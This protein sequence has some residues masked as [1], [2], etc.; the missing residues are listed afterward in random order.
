M[1][2]H[3]AN[4]L[5]LQKIGQEINPESL[6]KLDLPECYRKN[7]SVIGCIQYIDR[8]GNL[9]TNIHRS[10]VKGHNWSLEIK[11]RKIETRETY[12][13][14]KLGEL[15]AL[16]VSHGWVEVAVNSGNAQLALGVENGYQVRIF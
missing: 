9:V 10:Y 12:S 5:S 1:G 16:I 15:I 13:D 4:G 6:V 11:G 14:V 7:N 8:F 2:A 3:L